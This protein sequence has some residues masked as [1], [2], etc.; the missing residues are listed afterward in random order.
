VVAKL[1]E[2][3]LPKLYGFRKPAEI[4]LLLDSLAIE[5]GNRIEFGNLA[6]EV[7]IALNTLK[8]YLSAFTESHLVRLLY[9]YTKK[10]RE[11]ARQLKKSYIASPNLTCAM[12]R[13]TEENLRRNPLLGHLVETY[14]V[15]RF[16]EYHERI[17][18]WQRRGNEVDLVIPTKAGL[19]PIEV[20][21]R[22]SFQIK[23]LASLQAYFSKV[24][25]P[26][27]ILITKNLL[28]QRTL[29]DKSLYLIPAWM[30]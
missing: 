7:G 25:P 15:N 2:Y 13:L 4:A 19:I 12:H 23:D 3:D 5:T 28:E 29:N 9:N 27:G 21:Y 24:E 16:T 17:A 14:I 1:V 22:N 18:F 10:H 11:A 6:Q 8:D 26:F 20:K 30:V